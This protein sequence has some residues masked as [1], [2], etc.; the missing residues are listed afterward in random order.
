MLFTEILGLAS[1][2]L[3][4]GT[5]I[6]C[7]GIGGVVIVPALVLLNGISAHTAIASTMMAYLL[8]GALA[9]V[10]VWRERDIQVSSLGWLWLGAIPSALAG[11]LLA[12]QLPS[13]WIEMGVAALMLASG[14]HTLC[15]AKDTPNA[16]RLGAPAN[17][18]LGAITGAGSALTGTGGPLILVPALLWLAAPTLTAVRFGQS[19]QLP[20]A[21]VATLG[22]WFQGTLDLAIGF[23]LMASVGM[24]T[25]LGLRLSARIRQELLRRI[26]AVALVAL[27]LLMMMRFA[28][29]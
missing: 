25:A 18:V 5:L 23:V 29:G 22:N 13:N 2:G 11:A 4:A 1:V 6:G 8:S 12:P 21:S 16:R 27:A 3:V 9:A 19:I 24:G 15:Q 28:S 26:L 17:T 10:T 7:V 20:I 14:A